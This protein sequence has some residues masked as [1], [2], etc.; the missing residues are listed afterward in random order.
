MRTIPINIDNLLII[1]TDQYPPYSGFHI[2]EYLEK[3]CQKTCQELVI[4][5]FSAGVVGAI[6][7]A[8]GC[9]L[10]GKRV[11]QFIAF[12]GWGVPLQGNFPIYRISH[13]EFTHWSSA[14]LGTGKIS[15][16]ADPPVEHLALWRS[17]Q[18]VK[19]W[20]VET[21]DQGKKFLGAMSLME[22]L[23]LI[24]TVNF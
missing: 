7:A 6:S 17:P 23:S 9:Q 24:L 5:S 3:N 4:L 15:F 10:Q 1:P 16:Y 22:F 8:W 18:M 20:M 19:G 11:K 21:N 12:D 2:L 13:D 14:L